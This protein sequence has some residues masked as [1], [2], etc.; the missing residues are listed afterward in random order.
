MM[1]QLPGY[2]VTEQIYV[3]T[4]TLVYRAIADDQ[5]PVIIKLMRSEYPS[6]S[7]LVQFRNQYTIAKNL[8][9]PGIVKPYTLEPYRNGYVLLMEDFGGI[10]L[11]EWMVMRL[12]EKL[13]ITHYPLTITDFLCIAIQIAQTLEG[14]HRDRVIHKDIKPSNIVINPETQEVRLIDFSIASLLPRETQEYFTPNVLEGTLAYISPEQT[15][16][17]NCAIDYR[18][19]FYSLGVTFF[20]LLTGQLPFTRDDPMELVHCHIA[21]PTP[22]VHSLNPNIPL[23]VSHIV[24]KLMAK[25]AYLRYQSASGLKSDLSKC[26]SELKQTGSIDLFELGSRDICDRFL[27]PEKLYGREAEVTKLL[28]AFGRVA[29]DSATD[30]ATDDITDDITDVT[31]NLTVG[32][33][34]LASATSATTS[35]ATSATSPT[36]SVATSATSATTSVAAS[37][38]SATTSVAASATSP[39]TS[40]ATSATS[41]TTSVATSATSATTSVATSATSATTSVAT[42]ATSVAASATSATTSVAASATH[43]LPEMLLVAGFSGIGKTAVVNEVHKPIVAARGYFIKGKFDQL[44]RNIPF[45]GFVQAFRE[46]MRLLLGSGD[47]Q[48]QQWKSKILSALGENGQVIIEVIPELELIIGKQPAIA[49]LSGTAITN[50]F[51]L[52]LQKFISVFT[53][54]EHPLVIFLD[55]L[56]WADSASLKL[57]QLLMSQTDS[58]HLLLIAA[59][60]DNEVSPGHPLM[61]TLESIR[62]VRASINTIT[63]APLKQSD[64]N[65]LISDTLGCSKKIAHPLTELVYQKTKGN[66]FFSNQFLKSLHQ[67]GLI[68][69]NFKSCEW[70]CDLAQVRALAITDDVVE[71]MALQLQK[72]PESTQLVLKLAACIGNSF[73]LS[74][75]AIVHEKSQA[76]TAADLWKALQSGLISPTSEVYKFYQTETANGQL[77]IDNSNKQLTISNEQL[78]IYK[79]SHDRVQQ[80]AYSLIY[81]EKKKITHLKIGQLLLSNIPEAEREE[82]ILDIVNQLNIGVDL[83]TN[84]PERDELANLNLLA[85]RKAKASTAYTA[86]IEYFQVGLGLLVAN[87]WVVDYDLT[88]ALHVE[89]VET[90]YLSGNFEQMEELAFAV[91]QKAKSILDQVKVYEVK[92][93]AF[94]AQNKLLEAVDTALNI[95]QRLG[96]TFPKKPNKLNVVLGLIATKLALV[97]KRIAD[98]V[99]LPQMTDPYQISALRIFLAVSPALAFA[100][101]DLC[102]LTIFKKVQLSIK[103]GNSHE[104]TLAYLN[105]GMILCGILGNIET[106]Y[107]FGEIA[108]QLFDQYHVKQLKSIT[109]TLFYALIKHWKNHINTTL[110]PLLEACYSGLETGELNYAASAANLYS[111]H[112]YYSGKNLFKTTK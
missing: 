82:K 32:L 15:G 49:E 34:D 7:E 110:K 94:I 16:R 40:V 85:G 1:I 99:N 3:G 75:L 98:L 87:S 39:T 33:T 107:Q 109:F 18:T 91:F 103:Y 80:A 30:S 50:R 22:S 44:G 48:I 97:G 69:F 90:A 54:K 66:P 111:V 72:L 68:Y 2:S 70:E 35:V 36:T 6:F 25:N 46:L 64:L 26:L 100:S 76:E 86:A 10:S 37:A 58:S 24:A 13:P 106:G 104:S 88:L 78:A 28:Q 112:F 81:K 23:V 61:Q 65:N 108:V 89:A 31:D 101:P 105:Y 53:T 45:S 57:I 55:D 21:K 73:D 47:A 41:P 11:K 79:F 20:E 56:Q 63:L 8:D 4:K 84:Q 9:L 14:L 74:T 96:I 77:L 71:F 67:E 60:R 92:I 38:T 51:N 27:I 12:R 59:Y 62:K 93:Q 19:D 43:P 17:M 5:K 29:T 83:I 42:S 95:W 52:L 102:A